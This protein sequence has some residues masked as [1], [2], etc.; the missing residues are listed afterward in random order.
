MRK[1]IELRQERKEL[2]DKAEGI[3]KRVE[4]E[5]RDMNNLEVS[6]F[7]QL[8][9]QV[10]ALKT[11]IEREEQNELNEKAQF[12]AGTSGN[13]NGRMLVAPSC[14][15]LDD[16]IFAKDGEIR[17]YR[18]DESIA[19]TPVPPEFR[20]LTFGGLARALAIGPKSLSCQLAVRDCGSSAGRCGPCSS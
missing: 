12:E 19:T 4:A 11:D 10:E 3:T 16:S 2:L 15:N 14:I 8:C 7:N 20:G 18:S 9:L 13:G 5:R 6:Q 17:G 1:S